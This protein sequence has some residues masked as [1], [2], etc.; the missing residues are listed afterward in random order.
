MKI[1]RIDVYQLDI[2]LQKPKR[3]PN[4]VYDSLDDTIVRLETDDGIFGWGEVCPIASTYQPEHALG[5]RAAIEEMASGLIGQDPTQTDRI[6]ATM[7]TWLMG[8]E[9]A[10]SAIDIACW[11]ITGKAYGRPLYHL[12]GGRLQDKAACYPEI[13]MGPELEIVEKR[14]AQYRAE[15]FTH[16]QLKAGRGSN[17]DLD[18]D[19]IRKAGEC[20]RPGETLVVDANKAWRTHEAL[21]I[22]RAAEDIDFY[23]EQPCLTYEECLSIRRQVRQPMILDE[24]MTD[25][26]LMLRGLADNCFEGIGCKITRVGGITGMR[27]IRDVCT[28]AGKIMTVDD[29]WGADLSAAAQAHLSISTPATTFFAAYISTYFSDL[30]YDTNAPMVVDGFIDASEK[31]GLGVEPDMD[32]LGEPIMSYG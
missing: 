22:L 10:K 11:D 21:R 9:Y 28:A 17:F 20:V 4:K 2:P 27:L 23:I 14:I 16:F 13:E 5:V 25:I 15:G 31:P 6:N 19:R 3:Y 32:F 24:C 29:A 18:T 26:K 12:I 7:N 8:G 1:T 30:H